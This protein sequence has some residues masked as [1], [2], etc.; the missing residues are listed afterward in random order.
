MRIPGTGEIKDDK[1]WYNDPL[2]SKH[3]LTDFYGQECFKLPVQNFRNQIDK[4]YYYY[5]G[6]KY[7]AE[8]KF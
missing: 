6:E 5:G 4:G 1:H 3:F 8:G 7:K 2:I